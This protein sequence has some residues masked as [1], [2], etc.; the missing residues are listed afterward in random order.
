M[1][2]IFHVPRSLDPS[3]KSGFHVR[4]PRMVQGFRELGYEVCLISGTVSERKKKIEEVRDDIEKGTVYEFLYA[5]NATIPTLLTESGHLPISPKTDFGFFRFCKANGMRLGIFYRDIYWRF[6]DFAEK[7]NF[8]K[9]TVNVAFQYYDLFQF[10]SI[11]DVMYLPT[12]EM[13]EYLP[14][15]MNSL[16]KDLPP[17]VVPNLSDPYSH[18]SSDALRFLYVG[19]LGIF[20]NIEL[21]VKAVYNDSRLSLTIC[22]RESDW[23][24]AKHVYGEYICERIRVVHA[25]G[26]DLKALMNE[27]DIGVLYL[28]PH[29]WR[30]FAMPIKLFEYLQYGLPVFGVSGYA[31]GR[32]I[33]TNGI[34]WEI[35]YSEDS[36][37]CLLKSLI[38]N[39]G[40]LTE[41]RNSATAAATNHTWEKRCESVALDLRRT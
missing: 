10:S 18:S 26:E 13:A 5:E 7:M 16:I 33:R 40:N 12:L 38:E 39:A 34:G 3:A 11:F 36:L 19:G 14:I 27:A 25:S 41:I 1:K 9:R 32:F 29:E 30:D 35:A 22:C 6:P 21:M 24:Q 8:M 4:V 2:M 17:G 37:V 31:A 20:Y 23:K 28:E 15:K